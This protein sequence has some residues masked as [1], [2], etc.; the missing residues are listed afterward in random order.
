M[1]ILFKIHLLITLKDDTS[2]AT[3]RIE[4]D[5]IFSRLHELKLRSFRL[6]RP[7]H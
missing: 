3:C 1:I 5:D 2:I 6:H 4:R 7:E